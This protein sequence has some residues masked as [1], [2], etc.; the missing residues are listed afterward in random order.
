M[1]EQRANALA[2]RNKPS[3]ENGHIR[4]GPRVHLTFINKV[5]PRQRSFKS[6]ANTQYIDDVLQN[7]T[8]ETYIILL[9]NVT[10]INSE[11]DTALSLW[12]KDSS[13]NKK[14]S[15]AGL[16]SRHRL[17]EAQLGLEKPESGTGLGAWQLMR[18]RPLV[19]LRGAWMPQ[20]TPVL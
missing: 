19:L 3:G 10:P 9:T 7:C 15:I 6:L 4:A 14:H 20:N 2:P 17:G 11:R 13:K 12:G 8:P 18:I 16:R 1:S 5:N